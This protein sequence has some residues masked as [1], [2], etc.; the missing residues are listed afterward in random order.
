M[1]A[2]LV[3]APSSASAAESRAGSSADSARTALLLTV[4]HDEHGAPITRSA[5]LTC[6]PVGGSHP[7]AGPACAEL[8]SVSG[9]ISAM[10]E[11]PN[12]CILIYDPVMVTAKGWW[13]GQPRSFQA[14]YANRCVL[15]R[16]TRAVFDF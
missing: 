11:G 2:V 16:Q 3:T 1:A 14:T 5:T 4:T 6:T 8:A 13:Q 15:Y 12:Y 10:S 9:D 7:A